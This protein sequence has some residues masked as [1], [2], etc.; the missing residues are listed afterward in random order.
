[1]SSM[2]RFASPSSRKPSCFERGSETPWA[3]SGTKRG[4][5]GVLF[6]VLRD[7]Y[8]EKVPQG[9]LATVHRIV[10]GCGDHPAILYILSLHAGHEGNSHA[11]SQIR[12]FAMG[13]LASAPT[14]IAKDIEVGSP[15][16]QTH[17]GRVTA[18][19]TFV[20]LGSCFSSDGDSDVVN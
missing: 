4:Q 14:G 3:P 2:G 8:V 20:V 11:R 9:F 5:V 13:L 18:P 19:Q 7:V 1:M 12:V 15:K 17:A 16:I 6:I 10:L